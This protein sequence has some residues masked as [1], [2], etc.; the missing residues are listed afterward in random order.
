M[1]SDMKFYISV[2]V[3]ILFSS[4]CKISSQEFINHNKSLQI[5]IDEK[6]VG[7]SNLHLLVDK[8][9][10]KLTVFADTVLLKEYPVVFGG[11][12]KDDKLRQGDKCTPEGTFSILSKYEHKKWSKFIWIDYPN[13]QSWIKHNAAK[14]QGKISQDAK[15]GGE[16]GIH[17]VPDGK[18]FL[19]D[20]NY[21]WTLGCISLK[22]SDINE[23]YNI[24][25]NKTIVVIRK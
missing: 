5:V 13:E 24:I 14:A 19:I 23:I 10:Y 16:I 21:N 2:F 3:V 9:E 6:K 12:P 11:N 1:L 4:S 20:V 15:I 18:D 7:T 25:S 22:N 8:S 17:G